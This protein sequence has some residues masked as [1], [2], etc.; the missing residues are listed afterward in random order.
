MKRFLKVLTLYFLVLATVTL[1][2]NMLYLY[3]QSQVPDT[4]SPMRNS[5]A[6]I[7][8]VPEKI[9]VACFGSSHAL[10]GIDFEDC[11]K[12]YV[13]FNFGQASQFLSYDDR[14]LQYYLDYFEPNAAV[15]ITISHFS[16][17]GKPDT[18][19]GNFES[20]NKRYYRVLPDY[21]IKHYDRRTDFY[22][23]KFPSLAEVDAVSLISVLTGR[24]YQDTEWEKS[25]DL[26]DAA[27][28]AE[29]R[30]RAFVENKRA[31]DGSRLYN[32]EE[33]DALYH[34]IS[35]CRERELVPIMITTPYL[36]EYM[37]VIHKEDPD[38]L[39]DFYNL[40]NS[41]SEQ[42]DVPYY[43]FSEDPRFESCY[44][45]FHDADHLNRKGARAFTNILFKEVIKQKAEKG[46]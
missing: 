35:L 2:V 18:E 17:F 43:D 12:D 11:E 21:L 26:E 14:L 7:R 41:V 9:E 15:L 6:V 40:V 42:T 10:L 13:C 33:I 25:V 23:T 29:D 39:N 16:L 27:R 46:I 32:Q 30:Y 4:M 24:S 3:Q 5:N 45:L 44:E 19:Y 22:V 31:E 28:S 38:F 1:A 20:L 8:D 34:M 37:D 36:K